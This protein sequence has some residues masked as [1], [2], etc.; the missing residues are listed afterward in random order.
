M[1]PTDYI[2][3]QRLWIRQLLHEYDYI[4]WA[5]G[6]E[7][8]RPLFEISN[9]KSRYGCWLPNLRTIQ[10]S[11]VL[12]E[13]FSWDI[14]VQILKHELAHQICTEYFH[15][16][17]GGHGNTFQKACDMLGLSAQFR[18]ASG[19]LPS[20]FQASES[21]DQQT[22]AGRR[23]IEKISKLLALAG[24]ANE[25][26]ANLAMAKAG[27]L[28]DKHNLRQI[29]EESRTGYTHLIINRKK[30]RIEGYQRRICTILQDFFYVRI[31]FTSLYDAGRDESHRTIE[32]LGKEENVEVAEYVYHFLDNQLA[33]LWQQNRHK[34]HGNTRRSKNS[35]YLGL[36]DGFYRK[37]KKQN[38]RV[39][40][41][42]VAKSDQTSSALIVSEDRQLNH[43]VGNR[44]PRLSR[45]T[46]RGTKIYKE[47]YD[48]G[49]AAGQQI[50]L[51]QGI[52]KKEGN[53]GGL[54]GHEE[55]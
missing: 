6:L 42:T 26:E 25:H 47:S 28:M 22:G 24:S 20:G 11:S 36:L 40:K 46:L 17:L 48:D 9:S 44:H 21:L 37:L 1:P 14:A 38:E 29:E 7:L 49:V 41:G 45:R 8:Q 19:D 18:N 16:S 15:D 13:N 23:F 30:K 52:S 10:I 5:F 4:C 50:V 35:Y 54:L 2:A 53:Q 34:F 31:V 39:T 12:I 33:L 43:F 55:S 32:L 27:E 3:L 51:N